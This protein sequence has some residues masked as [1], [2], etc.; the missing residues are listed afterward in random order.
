MNPGR[1]TLLIPR[2]TQGDTGD[3]PCRDVSVSEKDEG[4]GP[5]PVEGPSERVGL[6]T[7]DC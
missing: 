6:S 2:D 3:A 1:A 7:G 4:G 5:D